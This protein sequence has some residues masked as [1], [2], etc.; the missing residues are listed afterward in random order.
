M[1][2]ELK[3]MVRLP[4]SHRASAAGMI[5]Y[6]WKSY[7]IQAALAVMTEKPDLLHTAAMERRLVEAAANAGLVDGNTG[8]CEPTVD[9]LPIEVHVGIVELLAATAQRGMRESH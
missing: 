8:K 9:G 2:S 7:A 6:G 4:R 3:G 5:G 1:F